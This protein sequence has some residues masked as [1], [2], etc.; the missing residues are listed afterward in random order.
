M[1]EGQ[2]IGLL[3][4]RL[5]D[6]YEMTLGQVLNAL[7]AYYYR[8]NAQQQE[9]WERTRFIM[10]AVLSPYS[11]KGKP[12]TPSQVL[13]FPW[14]ADDT[15]NTDAPDRSAMTQEEINAELKAMQDSWEKIDKK[16]NKTDG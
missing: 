4:M 14:D 7:N 11:K 2:C 9:Q 8:E 15:V 5:D 3:G 12:L 1:L 13:P 6:F 16:R 10:W